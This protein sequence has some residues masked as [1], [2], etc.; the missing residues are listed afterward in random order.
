MLIH[1]H[2]V[3][4]AIRA[5]GRRLHWEIPRKDRRWNFLQRVTI[6]DAAIMYLQRTV[7]RI[8]ILIPDDLTSR[9]GATVEL[10]RLTVGRIDVARAVA[11]VGGERWSSCKMITNDDVFGASASV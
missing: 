1:R 3:S 7:Q 10:N 11:T 5:C 6:N 2:S 9:I 8:A 4:S